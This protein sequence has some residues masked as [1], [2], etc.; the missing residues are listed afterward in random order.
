[1]NMRV[2]LTKIIKYYYHY[3]YISIIQFIS[4]FFEVNVCIYEIL[5]YL[6]LQILNN[7]LKKIKILKNI[8]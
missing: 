6:I 5:N 7:S 3:Y 4:L 2:N 8:F 1:M